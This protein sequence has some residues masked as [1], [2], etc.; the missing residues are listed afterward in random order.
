MGYNTSVFNKDAHYAKKSTKELTT[1]LAD[2]EVSRGK[3][4][5]M[6]TVPAAMFGEHIRYL[7]AKIAERIGRK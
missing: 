1:E 6:N 5:K 4:N 2:F 7:R 3:Y